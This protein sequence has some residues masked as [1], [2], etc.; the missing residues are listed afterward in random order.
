[1][2]IAHT[3]RNTSFFQYSHR[4]TDRIDCMFCGVNGKSCS[5]MAFRYRI[6][7]EYTQMKYHLE[8]IPYHS[9]AR[10]DWQMF[11]MRLKQQK[12]P[13]NNSKNSHHKHQITYITQTG[14]ISIVVCTNWIGKSSMNGEGL[15]IKGNIRQKAKHP[16]G[17]AI[18]CR[19]VHAAPDHDAVV[20]SATKR[21]K[22]AYPKCLCSSRQLPQSVCLCVCVC[23]GLPLVTRTL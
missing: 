18:A 16:N 12:K 3:T 22:S 17:T 6:N 15:A 13:N 20:A 1:M 4:S 5:H 14:S 9:P 23:A 19:F 8:P 2:R 21:L 11:H 10:F 7:Y